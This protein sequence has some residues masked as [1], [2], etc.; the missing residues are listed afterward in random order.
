MTE[1]VV[2]SDEDRN[3]DDGDDCDHLNVWMIC[4]YCY[5]VE[6]SA[7]HICYSGCCP[8]TRLTQGYSCDPQWYPNRFENCRAAEVIGDDRRCRDD[9]AVDSVVVDYY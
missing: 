2:D 9:V 7:L 3:D 8:V 4:D 6:Y 1:T 5:S